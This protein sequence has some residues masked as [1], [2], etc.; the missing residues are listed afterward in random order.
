M[1]PSGTVNVAVLLAPVAVA[2]EI[3]VPPIASSER[4]TSPGS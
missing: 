2:V 3:T 1:A 4:V